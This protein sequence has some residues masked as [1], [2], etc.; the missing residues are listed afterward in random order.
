MPKA[1]DPLSRR[2][3]PMGIGRS[4]QRGEL[5]IVTQVVMIGFGNKQSHRG[6][7]SVSLSMRFLCTGIMGAMAG[8]RFELEGCNEQ[9]ELI[10]IIAQSVSMSNDQQTIPPA[11]VELLSEDRPSRTFTV[12]P[13]HR[14]RSRELRQRRRERAAF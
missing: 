13:P 8:I 9:R 1:I 2:I 3:F 7:E 4:A 12:S 14:E 11:R 6:F 10:H 5:P